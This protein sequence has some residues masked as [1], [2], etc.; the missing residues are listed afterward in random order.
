MQ[1]WMAHLVLVL[2]ASGV[3]AMPI[4]WPPTAIVFSAA[5]PAV[6]LYSLATPE[7]PESAT[8]QRFVPSKQG[9]RCRLGTSRQSK[10]HRRCRRPERVIHRWGERIDDEVRLIAEGDVARRIDLHAARETHCV[11]IIEIQQSGSA[12][13]AS[14]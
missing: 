13:A 7:P 12:A 10:R 14:D 9:G 11:D 1:H 3:T 8:P 4:G 6:Y 2:L 5:P